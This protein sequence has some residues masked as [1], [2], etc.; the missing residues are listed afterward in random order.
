VGTDEPCCG[1]GFAGT[2]FGT[3]ASGSTGSGTNGDEPSGPGDSVAVETGAKGNCGATTGGGITGGGITGSGTTSNGTAG[4][5]TDGEFPHRATAGSEQAPGDPVTKPAVIGAHITN[6]HT[7]IPTTPTTRHS[8]T[9]PLRWCSNASLD[10]PHDIRTPRASSHRPAR[11]QALT[12]FVSMHPTRNPHDRNVPISKSAEQEL[13]GHVDVTTTG[14]YLDVRPG[15]LIDTHTRT[16]PR[17]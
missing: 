12:Q 9:P 15:L 2:G 6:A 8:H 16:H 17:A 10:T 14:K 11:R 5:E 3:D 1:E 4:S 13:L 7:P